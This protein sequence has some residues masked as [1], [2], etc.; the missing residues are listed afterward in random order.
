MAN[1][2]RMFN[3]HTLCFKCEGIH[4]FSLTSF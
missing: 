4:V 3:R 1:T 2:I